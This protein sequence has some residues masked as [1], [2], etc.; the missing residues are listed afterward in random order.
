MIKY[1]VTENTVDDY[2]TE[3]EGYDIKNSYTPE[4]TS[5]TVTKRWND[6]NDKDTH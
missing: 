2:N 1:T 6:S 3:I 4:E 5:V